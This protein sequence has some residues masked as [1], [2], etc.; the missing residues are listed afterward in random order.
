MPEHDSHHRRPMDEAYIAARELSAPHQTTADAAAEVV[1]LRQRLAAATDAQAELQARLDTALAQLARAAVD[2]EQLRAENA[3]L[4]AE[5]EEHERMIDARDEGIAW[6]RAE[7][8][9]FEEMGR[10]LRAWRVYSLA[11]AIWRARAWLK[12]RWPW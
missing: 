9:R 11:R 5:R 4:V 12:T 8:A 6:L 1:E 2:V 3:G 7:L 10:F